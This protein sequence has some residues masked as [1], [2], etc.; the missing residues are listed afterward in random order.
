VTIDGRLEAL[1]ARHEALAITLELF[2][3]QCADSEA[4]AEARRAEY[5]AKNEAR[6][7]RRDRNLRRWDVLGVKEAR[8]HGQR[9]QE[10]ELSTTRL[11][12][13]QLVTEEKLAAY[14]SSLG[15]HHN[16]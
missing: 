8:K 5:E 16:A 12:A 14:S 1:A 10:I 3:R 7:A 2:M 15:I 6:Q 4:K 9:Q 11:A 13:A